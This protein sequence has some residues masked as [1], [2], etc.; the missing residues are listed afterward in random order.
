MLG[1]RIS[2]RKWASGGSWDVRWEQGLSI[3]H[4]KK[5]VDNT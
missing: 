2:D 5:S 3:T 1:D 4:S